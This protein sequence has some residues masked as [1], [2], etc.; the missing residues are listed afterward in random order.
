MG[1]E[2]ERKFRVVSQAWRERVTRS[3]EF[4]QA[5]I[6][7]TDKAVVGVKFVNGVL[8]AAHAKVMKLFADALFVGQAQGND[9]DVGDFHDA[10][11]CATQAASRA[12]L[13]R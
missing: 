6:A 13:A 2:I 8:L 4:R 12:A 7:E 10:A 3:R 9:F 1:L 5:Y 11:S